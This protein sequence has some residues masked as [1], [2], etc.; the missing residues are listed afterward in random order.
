MVVTLW[1]QLA[2]HVLFS[3][4]FITSVYMSTKSYSY[5]SSHQQEEKKIWQN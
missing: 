3:S 2:C 1:L 5:F 4:T